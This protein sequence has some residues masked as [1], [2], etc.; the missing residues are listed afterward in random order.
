MLGAAV[1]GL[2]SIGLTHAQVVANT[3]GVQLKAVAEVDETKLGGVL[4]NLSSVQG[5][6]DYRDALGRDDVQEAL[7]CLPHWLHEEAVIAASEAGK[8]LLVEKPLADS[9]VEC[10]RIIEAAQR[11]NVVLMP[12]HTHRYYA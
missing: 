6:G 10:D 7:I 11:N 4:D 5:Y 1:L 12:A 2:G 3:P 9:L 8:H